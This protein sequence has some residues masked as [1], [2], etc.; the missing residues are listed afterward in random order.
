VQNAR[1]LDGV[2]HGY[3]TELCVRRRPHISAQ[4]R[5]H[6][7]LPRERL[8][9]CGA[10]RDVSMENFFQLGVQDPKLPAPDHR[11][12][13][14]GG[15]IERVAKGVFTDHSRRAHDYNAFLARRRNTHDSVRSS[16]Q[17]T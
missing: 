2:V 5:N 15:M 7:V 17:S 13:C 10:I 16:I 8:P 12:T 9:E 6:C 1:E 11:R 4:A 14:H 3:F